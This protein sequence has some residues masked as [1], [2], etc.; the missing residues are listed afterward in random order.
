MYN[1]GN[2]NRLIVEDIAEV[3]QDYTSIQLDIDPTR[4]KAAALVAQNDIKRAIGKANLQRCIEPLTDEDDA[5]KRL[6]IPPLCYYTYYRCL[7]MFQGNFTDSGY[8]TETGAE[9]RNSA[10]SVAN[11]YH[12]IGDTFMMEVFDFLKSEEPGD[13]TKV[14]LTPRVRVFGGTEFRGNNNLGNRDAGT[15]CNRK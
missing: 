6:I 5:L 2:E 8:T 13:V 10:K 15:R 11:T 1:V 9:D 3:M 12:S 14:E 4:V 7:K